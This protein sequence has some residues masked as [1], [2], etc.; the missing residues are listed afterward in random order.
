MTLIM[1]GRRR[2]NNMGG[3]GAYEWLRPRYTLPANLTFN[4]DTGFIDG[5]TY[6]PTYSVP[7]ANTVTL[8]DQGSATA[9]MTALQNAVNNASTASGGT[10][11]YLPAG[12]RYTGNLTL[13]ANTS[14][15]WIYLLSGSV[16]SLPALQAA[17]A[18]GTTA[19]RVT[20]SHGSFMPVLNT[21]NGSSAI[22]CENGA[23]KYWLRGVKIDNNAT[24][25]PNSLVGWTVGGSTTLSDYPDE[26]VFDQCWLDGNAPTA[27]S[28]VRA[29]YCNSRRLLVRNCLVERIGYTGV[30]SQ[31]FVAISGP[32]PY[33]IINNDS[34]VG[35]SSENIMFGGADF[36][37]GS[38]SAALLPC[39]I[40]VRGNV[41]RKTLGG[42]HKN[43]VEIKHGKRIL[44][45]GNYA[46]GHNGGGQQV[47]FYPATIA[48]VPNSPFADTSDV[49]VRFNRADI[50][51]FGLAA[52][53]AEYTGSNV[54]RR[55]ELVGNLNEN[56]AASQRWLLL[57]GRVRDVTVRHNTGF[58]AAGNIIRTTGGNKPQNLSITQNVLVRTGAGDLSIWSE[59]ASVGGAANINTIAETFDG[60]TNAMSNNVL[61]GT[62]TS[63]ANFMVSTI[64]AVGFTDYAGGDFTLSSSSPGYR[65]GPEGQD[66]GVPWALYNTL[67]SGRI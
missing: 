1:V 4:A 14:G 2:G 24:Q 37:G 42:S 25:S 9:N 44:I 48:S 5:G 45:E 55:I 27:A 6:T 7:T 10:V 21:G 29:F 19:H 35:G 41:F 65:A 18:I 38:T 58:S 62:E 26:I 36:A 57:N 46:S 32:G 64:T 33:R 51:A 61:L 3:V 11:I 28:V 59:Q 49:T 31:F 39:D 34:D 60:G 40:E 12:L 13:K 67:Q 15:G 43:H 63:A 30:D 50:Y 8:T 53:Q 52:A 54:V 66:L 20:S 47:S 23:S 22:K 16:G 56:I 17:D